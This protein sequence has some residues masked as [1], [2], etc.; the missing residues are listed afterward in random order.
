MIG[1][2]TARRRMSS[3]RSPGHPFERPSTRSGNRSASGRQRS[4]EPALM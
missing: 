4:H 2:S 3:Q 1:R